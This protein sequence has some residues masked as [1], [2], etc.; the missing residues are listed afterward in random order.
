MN[1]AIIAVLGSGTGAIGA[2]IV[3]VLSSLLNRK[4]DDAAVAEQVSKAWTP[5]VA[6]LRTEVAETKAEVLETKAQ[7]V[8]C[9]AELAE[10]KTE[11]DQ[12]KRVL[13]AA[14]RAYDAQ[15]Q[16]ATDAAVNEARNL[17]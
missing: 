12:V 8:E 17:L 10:C 7:C 6:E 15:D 5:L 4:K 1:A 13:N 11:L 9:K 16:A 3:A 2:I 14:V